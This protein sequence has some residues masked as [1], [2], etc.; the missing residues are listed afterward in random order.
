MKLRN[1]PFQLPLTLLQVVCPESERVC[2]DDEGLSCSYGGICGMSQQQTS[3]STAAEAEIVM[4]GE[5]PVVPII[6]LLGE[7][8]VR[9]PIGRPYSRCV[10]TL[11]SHCD[12]GVM[13]TPE[14]LTSKVVACGDRVRGTITPQT[15]M[16]V[17]V[18]YCGVD[19]S[20]PGTYSVTYSVRDGT[21][22]VS[23]AK[24][25]VVIEAPCSGGEFACDD[26]SCSIGK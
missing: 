2:E 1:A 22:P 4:I 14:E 6:T 8:T 23:Y 25:T 11:T 7:E 24:R 10:G 16:A 17:G 21:G 13:V 20:K 9:I 19:T 12:L 15:Y 26:G 5:E 3:I 18:L